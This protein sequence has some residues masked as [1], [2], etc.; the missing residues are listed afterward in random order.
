M[1][2]F[3]GDRYQAEGVGKAPGLTYLTWRKH[4][5]ALKAGAIDQGV[6]DSV[7]AEVEE[8]VGKEGSHCLEPWE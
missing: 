6:G 3:G 7:A 2:K 8:K 1:W 5:E 4:P